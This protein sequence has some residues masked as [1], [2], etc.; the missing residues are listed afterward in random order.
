MSL[1]LPGKVRTASGTTLKLIR[2]L[3][4]GGQGSVYEVEGGR[5]AVKVLREASSERA[6]EWAGRL[7][8]LRRLPLDGLSVA[9]PIDTLAPPHVGY[10]MD[11]LDGLTPLS[12]LT[13][14]PAGS[15]AVE[16][17]R[18]TGGLR[19]RLSLLARLAD[20][21]AVLHARG[22]VYQ[23]PSPSNIFVSELLDRDHVWLID[24]DNVSFA[25]ARG[26][27][28]YTRR[29]SAPE[30]R[31]GAG[32]WADSLSDIF[33]FAVVAFE[34]LTL[35]HPFVGDEL[36]EDDE[37][38]EAEALNGSHPWVDHPT[39]RSNVSTRGIQPRGLVLPPALESMFRA[40]FVDGLRRRDRRP[41]AGR[42]ADALR[43]A[44]TSVVPCPACGLTYQLD[45]SAERCPWCD[46]A[47]R[48]PTLHVRLLL[49]LPDGMT[50]DHSR[51]PVADRG[52][53][54]TVQGDELR[55]S[56]GFVL[57]RVADPNRLMLQLR[58]EG[59]H[60]KIGNYAGQA[61]ELV[62]PDGSK[63]RTLPHERVASIRAGRAGKM[64]SLRLARLGRPNR[65]LCF[66]TDPGGR[67]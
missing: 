56:R 46:E 7:K 28:V 45:L 49:D 38:A 2:E 44:G 18:D 22:L 29:Y 66:A 60:M 19:R 41:G 24:T 54:V 61:I 33:A 26:C 48:P 53:L 10:V 30:L 32:R 31:P 11:L 47:P 23:D 5:H 55:V 43:D 34:L 13:S 37:E 15:R 36:Y 50:P 64:W 14:V 42:W 21:L 52:E 27:P 51:P 20:V 62:A 16:H 67:Q 12:R 57:G 65:W 25:G 63:F 35:D 8:A 1:T 17:Y 59:D 4:R 39:D 9:S 58:W 40:T 6:A 3:G